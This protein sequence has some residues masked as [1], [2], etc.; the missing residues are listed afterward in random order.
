MAEPLFIVR[1]SAGVVMLDSR[2]AS[3]GACV[4]LLEI[5]ANTAP[6]YT[7]P[8]HVGRSAAVVTVDG[9]TSAGATVDTALGYPRVSFTLFGASSRIVAVF[10][11]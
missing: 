4:D 7:Y 8:A 2:D 3:G 10:V 9:F 5:A 6:V 11:I 1:N